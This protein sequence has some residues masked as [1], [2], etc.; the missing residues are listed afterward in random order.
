MTIGRT[1]LTVLLGILALVPMSASQAQGAQQP[2]VRKGTVQLDC[3]PW[4][5]EAFMISLPLP[6]GSG[7]LKP[8]VIVSFWIAPDVPGPKTFVF[9]AN[10]RLGAASW[11]HSGHADADAL[12]GSVRVQGVKVGSNVVGDLDLQTQD[13]TTFKFTFEAHWVDLW[14]G[15]GPLCG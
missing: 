12:F 2:E 3:A 4:D 14:P 6:N 15:A 11:W 5:G 8:R 1:L 10:Q 7:P 9:D 13:G